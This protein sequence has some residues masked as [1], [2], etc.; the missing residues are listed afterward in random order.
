MELLLANKAW[1]F[2]SE[3]IYGTIGCKFKLPIYI[4]IYIYNNFH[5]K[6]TWNVVHQIWKKSGIDL[7]LLV[8]EDKTFF[9][10]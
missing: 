10:W 7:E 1:N 6:R 3:E 9:Y 2:Y 8:R 4:Y 5:L